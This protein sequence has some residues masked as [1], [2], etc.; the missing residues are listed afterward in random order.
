[1]TEIAESIMKI[2]AFQNNGSFDNRRYRSILARVHLTP[3]EFEADQKNVLL[4][5][6]LTRI[7]MGAAKVSE[8]EARQWYD[9]QNTSVNIDY[10]LFEP[11]RIVISSLHRRKLPPFFHPKRKLQNRPHG[12]GPIRGIRPGPLKARLTLMRMKLQTT[13]IP[14]STISKPKKP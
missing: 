9:W 5:E 3:E 6:K 4:G 13:M 14:T 2:A 1:M 8:A 7:I 10:V 12:Q 11:A